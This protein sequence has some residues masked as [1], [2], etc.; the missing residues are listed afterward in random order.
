MEKT[1]DCVRTLRGHDH[2]VSSVTFFP[3]GDMLASASRDHSVR[4]WEVNTT[5][6]EHLSVTVIGCDRSLC[7][8][9]ARRW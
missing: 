9:T 4:L 5:A 2:N 8:M 3:S 1:Y 7:R 6:Y